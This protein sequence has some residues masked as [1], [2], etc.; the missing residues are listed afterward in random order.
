MIME[1]GRT[2]AS[3]GIKGVVRR[4]D[5]DAVVSFECAS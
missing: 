2:S 4:W 1:S 3:R 5:P